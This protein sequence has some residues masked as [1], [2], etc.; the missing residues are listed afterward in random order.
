MRS[1]ERRTFLVDEL[2]AGKANVEQLADRFDVSPSTIRRD[3]QY[4][5]KN[6]HI[7]RTYGGAVLNHAVSEASFMER[8]EKNGNKK[9]AIARAALDLIRDGDTLMLDAGST[10]CAFGRLLAGRKLRVVT[11]NLMLVPILSG[12]QDIE[13]I[14]LGGLCRP[15]SMGTFGSLTLE[16]LSHISAD[17]LFTSAD[18]LAAG[19]G[20]CEANFDQIILKKNMMAQAH[21]TVVLVDSSKISHTEH[22]AWV[23]LP[24]NWTLISDTDMSETEKTAFENDGAKVIRVS[25]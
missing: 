23:Q 19:K 14:I 20:L 5:A 11:N 6:G 7:Q 4:L 8:M 18:G 17:Y 24:P 22:H 25:P 9:R 12:L 10:V 21:K 1:K 16:A 13:L 3:L 2:L 15:T